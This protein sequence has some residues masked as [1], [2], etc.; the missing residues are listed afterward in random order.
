MKIIKAHSGEEIKVDDDSYEVLSKYKWYVVGR[1]LRY[2]GR[3]TCSKRKQKWL[4]MAREIMGAPAG[5]I[6]DH[7]NH[8]T[9]DNRREN[10]RFVTAS[11]SCMNRGKVSGK[12][13]TNKSGHP[14]LYWDNKN[15]IWKA[16]LAVN[17]KMYVLGQG[18]RDYCLSLR[19]AAEVKHFGEF[20]YKGKDVLGVRR[21]FDLLHWMIIQDLPQRD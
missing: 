8:D 4:L 5:S 17:K 21:G 19:L 7:I 1:K 15:E 11:Q 3:N 6:V 18:A 13:L 12:V 2:A 14:G 10:L 9:L 20:R 16:T